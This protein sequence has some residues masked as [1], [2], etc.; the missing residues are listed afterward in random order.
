MLN[1]KANN[2]IQFDL[3][4][5]D[6]TR[7]VATT[8]SNINQIT[9]LSSYAGKI[10]SKIRVYANNNY[11]DNITIKPMILHTSTLDTDFIPHQEQTATL[12]L[13][14][15]YL[16]G[17]PNTDYKDNINPETK[18]IIR[19][20]AKIDSYNG[21]TITTDYISTTGGLDT[22][23]TIYYGLSTPTEE[24]ITD[25]TLINN[26]NAIYNLMGYDGTTNMTIISAN[27]N[28]QLLVEATALKG[29]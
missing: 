12:N 18:K 24:T 20:T 14:T 26:L 17:I 8:L 11:N 7:I 29:E 27:G 23:A 9:D 13:G 16:A 28:A 22:G 10:V 21:E 25:T 1:N 2:N 6:N 15:T 5:S 4:L 3:Y 19:K